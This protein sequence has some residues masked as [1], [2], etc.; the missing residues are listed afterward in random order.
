MN[1]SVTIQ[2]LSWFQVIALKNLYD[3]DIFPNKIGIVHES[4]DLVIEY[5]E[6]AMN[7]CGIF[8]QMKTIKIPHKEP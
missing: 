6:I 7:S 8:S 1:N 4:G 3:N 5:E 2:Q